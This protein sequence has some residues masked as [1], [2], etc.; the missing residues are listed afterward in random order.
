LP[1]PVPVHPSLTTPHLILRPWRDEDL[2]PF[3]A[4]NADPRVVQY[5]P[6][7]LTREQSDAA[8]SRLREHFTRH[9]FG[10]WV[11]R[12]RDADDDFVG[13]V[14]L[15]WLPFEAHFT[16][17]VEIGWR[18]AHEHWGRGYA[19]ESAA[20]A[21]DYGFRELRLREIVAC[22]VP[23]N[24]RSLAVM[25]RLGMTRSPNDDFDHPQLTAGHPLRRHVLFRAV[26]PAV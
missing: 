24:T 2:A 17:A 7:A 25:Q 8:A 20:A 21:L 1:Q 16:P 10:K 26:A 18:L 22:T 12:T 15:A 5:L 11:V 9:G 6:A 14:G 13:V 3:A 4:M 19:T 23:A